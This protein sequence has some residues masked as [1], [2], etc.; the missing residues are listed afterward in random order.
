M[1]EVHPAITELDAVPITTFS[2]Q[3]MDVPFK[4]NAKAMVHPIC[5]QKQYSPRRG[6]V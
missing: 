2:S 4:P 6:R 1:L 5:T 3:A